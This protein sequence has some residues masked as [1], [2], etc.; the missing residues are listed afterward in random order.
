[1]L[2]FIDRRNIEV[3]DDAL[4]AVLRQKTP[5][6]RIA[7]TADANETARKMAAAGIHHDHPDWTQRDIERE[8]A[9]RMLREAD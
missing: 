6:E 8:V 9:R 2:R 4:A 1:M 5:A 7:M 3:V